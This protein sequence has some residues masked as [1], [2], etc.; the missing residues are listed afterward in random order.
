MAGKKRSL[1]LKTPRD[2]HRALA[3]MVN[4]LRRGEIKPD[5]A[6]KCGYLLNIM[7]AAMREN[8]I[9]ERLAMIERQLESRLAQNKTSKLRRVI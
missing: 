7:L 4:E 8:E 1:K 6:S 2:V 5:I 3:K 9:E